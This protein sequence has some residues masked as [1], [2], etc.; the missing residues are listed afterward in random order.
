MRSCPTARAAARA[1][2]LQQLE[3]ALVHLEQV[4][5]ETDPGHAA[6]GFGLLAT[7]DDGFTI[8]SRVLDVA[9]VADALVGFVAPPEWQAFGLVTRGRTRP[10]D[11]TGPL[12]RAVEGAEPTPVHVAIV[13]SRSGAVVSGLRTEDGPFEVVERSDRV[14][15]RIPDACRR[16]LGLATP[17]PEV[18]IGP[19][20]ALCWVEDVVAASVEDP[21]GLTWADAVDLHPGAVLARELAV[22]H[23]LA[24]E[25]T[26]DQLLTAGQ[27][28]LA[29]RS[30]WGQ[31]RHDT[32][33]RPPGDGGVDPQAAAWMD[34]GMFSREVLAGLLPADALLD[35]LEPVARPEVVDGV[36]ALLESPLV[37]HHAP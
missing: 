2:D 6:L 18:A 8:A 29:E 23:G 14:G 28:I 34:D 5:H 1:H 16:V 19:V 27:L 37:A 3:Q 10:L 12:P 32:A 26:C 20:I 21:G 30:T 9:D 17:P 24:D 7:D 13:V 35:L 15:G 31:L 25:L 22:E 11:D 4:L 36:T 33:V